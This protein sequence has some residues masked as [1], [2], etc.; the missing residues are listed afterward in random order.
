M[1]GHEMVKVRCKG[2]V[3]TLHRKL[4]K[5]REFFAENPGAGR[6]DFVILPDM[7]MSISW[8]RYATRTPGAHTI[9]P[10][11]GARSLAMI[12]KGSIYQRHCG[13]KDRCVALSG[14][15]GNIVKD[16]KAAKRHAYGVNADK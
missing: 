7:P 2:G 9:V 11:S 14:R 16:R 5:K 3:R 8:G 6:H 10:E 12:L 1:S 15:R 4:M 13:P